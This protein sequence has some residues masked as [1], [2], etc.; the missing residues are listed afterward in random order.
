MQFSSGI[1]T[2]L[3]LR[4]V[5]VVYFMTFKQLFFSTSNCCW[6][7]IWFKQPFG[8]GPHPHGATGQKRVLASYWDWGIGVAGGAAFCWCHNVW[9]RQVLRHCYCS[10]KTP[11]SQ[12]R[13]V[14]FIFHNLKQKK[15]Q[16]TWPKKAC[17]LIWTC[18]CCCSD[19]R[20]S[21][22]WMNH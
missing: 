1:H 7:I 19:G 4:W 5:C 10:R 17:I 15:K 6:N 22:S 12:T 14:Y 20:K 9:D 8:L 3:T 11:R 16:N 21:N 18:F 2:W 13:D